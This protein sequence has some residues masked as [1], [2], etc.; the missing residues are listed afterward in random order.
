MKWL[1][2]ILILSCSVGVFSADVANFENLGFS[3]NSRYFM[4][5]QYGVDDSKSAPYAEIFIINVSTNKYAPNGA[6]KV[7]YQDS[8]LQPGQSGFGA[9]ITLLKNKAFLSSRYQ[10]NHMKPGRFLYIL[11]NGSEPG[12]T[13]NFRDFNTG[14]RYY[15]NLIQEGSS[16]YIKLTVTNSKGVERNYT[17]GRPGYN[18]KWVTGYKIWQ[19]I[20]S[21]DEKSLI[22][23]IEKEKRDGSV[24]YMIETVSIK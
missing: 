18:R 10:I 4:F 17:V 2:L 19:V 13:L 7:T 11:V 24:R 5:G 15:V 12:T 23:V 3:Y 20:L 8:K 21:P 1:I 6:H 16:F 22:F 9:L 14:F